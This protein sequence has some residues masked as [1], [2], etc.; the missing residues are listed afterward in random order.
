[1]DTKQIIAE[2]DTQIARLKEER[3]ILTAT[4]VAAK[5]PIGKKRRLSPEAIARIVAAQKRGP[6]L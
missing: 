1:M 4:S 3:T 5:L 2:L 6:F